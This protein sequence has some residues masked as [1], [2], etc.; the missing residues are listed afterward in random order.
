MP[1]EKAAIAEALKSLDHTKD[2]LWTDDGSPLVSEIQRLANDKTITRAQINDALPGF[3]RKS[4]ASITEPEDDAED[5]NASSD[6]TIIAPASEVQAAA[7]GEPSPE[8]SA[9]RLR[10]IAYQRVLDAESGIADAKVALSA[11]LRAVSDAEARHSRALTLYS[12][13]YP[14]L[15]AAANIKQHLASQMEVQR[16]RV[17][18]SRFV[19]NTAANPVDATL[20]DRKR[21]NGRNGRGNASAPASFLP[22]SLAAS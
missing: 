4:E 14:P 13:K 15:S 17:E 1:T 6:E 18:G 2:E 21:N 19:P 12:S 22:R 10:K 9:E 16:Q 7:D 5:V 11:A 8:Q 20:Q 3:V